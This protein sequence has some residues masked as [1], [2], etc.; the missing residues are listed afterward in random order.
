MCLGMGKTHD[1]IM[2][3]TQKKQETIMPLCYSSRF[4]L[5]NFN[6][7]PFFLLCQLT[8]TMVMPAPNKIFIFS[9]HFFTK[10]KVSLKFN[11][12]A[13]E[14]VALTSNGIKCHIINY[15]LAFR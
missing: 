8:M 1:Y 4:L 3:I 6:S 12:S 11:H 7:C 14:A 15:L 2:P 10:I 13:K 5:K 9:F